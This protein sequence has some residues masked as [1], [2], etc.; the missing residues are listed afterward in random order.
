MLLINKTAEYLDEFLYEGWAEASYRVH[1]GGEGSFLISNSLNRLAFHIK[2]E[3]IGKVDYL[4]I[5]EA[6]AIKNIDHYING[7][8]VK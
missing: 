3:D 1:D 5:V 8:G 4:D 2:K 7:R 6:A